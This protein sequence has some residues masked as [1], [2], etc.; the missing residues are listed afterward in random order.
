MSVSQY[1]T[2]VLVGPLWC[3]VFMTRLSLEPDLRKPQ[4][5]VNP[6]GVDTVY[7]LDPMVELQEVLI[8]HSNL[9]R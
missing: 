4:V 3:G 7:G 1:S 9:Q 6:K 5:T 2:F 8:I